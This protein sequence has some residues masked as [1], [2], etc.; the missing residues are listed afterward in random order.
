MKARADPEAQVLDRFA[1]SLWLGEGLA[2]NTLESYRRD[3]AQFGAWLREAHGR[4]L[5][6]AEPADLQGHLAWLVGER[7]A[8][9]RTTARLVSSLRRFYQFALREGLRRDD[10]TA[11]LESPKLPRSLPKSL[12]EAEVEALL[13]APNEESSQGLRDRAM[14]SEQGG[15]ARE[16]TLDRQF[17]INLSVK[18]KP[19]SVTW[20]VV[21]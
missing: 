7:K 13:A 17:R 10:P 9:P 1:D 21:K 20:F 11:R 8:K 4:R 12:S 19:Q 14:V 2:K 3:L 15:D 18:M 16:Y 5:L 6:E